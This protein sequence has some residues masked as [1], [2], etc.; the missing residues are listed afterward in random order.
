MR[1]FYGYRRYIP[2]RTLIKWMVFTVLTALLLLL[3]IGAGQMRT[4]L[5]RLATTRVS[6]TVN[7]LV[8]ET[9]NDAVEKGTFQYDRMISFE[10]DNNGAITAVKSNMTEFNRLQAEILKDILS[11]VSEV[12]TKDLS[13]PVGTLTGTSLLAGRGPGI[14]VRMQSVG[15]STAMLENEFTSAGINQTKHRILLKVDVSVSILL[16]GFATATKVSNAITVAETIIVGDVPDSYT[17][18]H[19]GDAMDEIA[20]DRVLNEN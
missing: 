7:R 12:S 1:G 16:P 15:S 19:S 11:K 17:Y 20:K 13:I 9:V 14:K 6:S 2:R 8:S 18:F 10:K 3:I 5:T 4:I